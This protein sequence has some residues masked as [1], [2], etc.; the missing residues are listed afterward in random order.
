MSYKLL[1]LVVQ[2]HTNGAPRMDC[3]PAPSARKDLATQT[4]APYLGDLRELQKRA[5]ETPRWQ[6]KMV[7]THTHTQPTAPI[8][9]GLGSHTCAHMIDTPCARERGPLVD[10]GSG[11]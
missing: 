7:H 3:S 9:D 10:V 4:Y 6:R 8:S 11:A 1:R 5:G 2:A